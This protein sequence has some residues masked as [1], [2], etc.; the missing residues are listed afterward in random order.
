MKGE[1]ESR[2]II[3]GDFNTPV[4]IMY[5][6]TTP[7]VNKETED[8]KNIINELDLIVICRTL[9]NSRMYIILKH[10]QKFSRIDHV[11]P[12]NKS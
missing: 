4:S 11:R 1:I 9:Y 2:T 3:I 6:S 7:K 10:T 5:R 12:Q 8:L